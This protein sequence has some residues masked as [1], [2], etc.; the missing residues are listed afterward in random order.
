MTR[1]F[2][3]IHGLGGM[4]IGWMY[5]PAHIVDAM[6]RMRGPFNV[7]AAAIEAGVAAMRDRAHVEQHRRAQRRLAVVADARS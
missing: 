1:T 4:R 7:N 5:A 2:S 3:K 6:N